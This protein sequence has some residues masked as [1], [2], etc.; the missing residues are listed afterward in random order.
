[1]WLEAGL[2]QV[3]VTSRFTFSVEIVQAFLMVSVSYDTIRNKQQKT[4]ELSHQLELT[5]HLKIK[6]KSI[7]LWSKS[8]ISIDS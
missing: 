2:R 4:T 8:K 3:L 6:G 5:N 7:T 1:M